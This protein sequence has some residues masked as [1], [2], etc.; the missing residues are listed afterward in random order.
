MPE[1]RENLDD[2]IPNYTPAH[3]LDMSDGFFVGGATRMPGLNRF[4][5]L[6]K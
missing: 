6:S 5:E 1:Q 2:S 4:R 3:A